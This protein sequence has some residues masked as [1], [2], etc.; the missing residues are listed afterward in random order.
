MSGGGGSGGIGPSGPTENIDCARLAFDTTLASPQEAI[1]AMLA[2][3]DALDLQ[4][5]SSG[6]WDVIAAVT[7]SGDVAGS[8]TDRTPDLLR[9]MQEGVT[10]VAE[11]TAMS[12][13]WIELHVHA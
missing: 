4:I 11:I 1:V 8:I 3:G 12:G 5:R 10:Y 2:V 7:A 13:G 9:C 6:G